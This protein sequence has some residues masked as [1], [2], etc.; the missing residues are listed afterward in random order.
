MYIA[1][2]TSEDA[3]KKD[4]LSFVLFQLR[5]VYLLLKA[6][7]PIY[8]SMHKLQSILSA[9]HTSTP[10]KLNSVS[11]S[12]HYSPT[13]GKFCLYLILLAK[14][15]S[16][17]YVPVT[18]QVCSCENFNRWLKIFLCCFLTAIKTFC[19]FHKQTFAKLHA[20]LKPMLV[21]PTNS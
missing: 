4:I 14:G 7:W 6:Y 16:G 5:P 9:T 20:T 18:I 11:W 10:P 12:I 3:L 1:F 13:E 17:I 2:S 19:N 21:D 15:G 8:I